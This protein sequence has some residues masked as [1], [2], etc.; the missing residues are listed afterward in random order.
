MEAQ[1]HDAQ[2]TPAPIS[3]PTPH[4]R[5]HPHPPAHTTPRPPVHRQELLQEETRAKLALGSRARAL[6]AEAAGLREQLD[7]EAAARERAG[8][9]RQAAQ[10]QVS[11]PAGR[12]PTR[13]LLGPWLTG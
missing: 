2:V 8:R 1:L 6:E 12:C 11:S 4:P 9:E 3:P 7:E 13:L 10:A 5:P